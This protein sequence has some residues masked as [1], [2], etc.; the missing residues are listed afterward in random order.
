MRIGWRIFTKLFVVVCCAF[1]LGFGWLTLQ[2][3]TAFATGGSISGTVTDEENNPLANIGVHLYV[4]P[5]G[6]GFW[7]PTGIYG[8]TDLAGQYTIADLDPGPYRLRFIDGG[9]PLGYASEYYNN[10][11]QLADAATVTVADAQNVTIDA[12]LTA[13]SRI[14]GL[15][16]D[17]AGNPIGGI[18]VSL[19]VR[20]E[21]NPNSWV[22]AG[23]QTTTD[24]SG[25]YLVPGIDTGR[26]RVRFADTRS[27]HL[28]STEYYVD[29][30]FAQATELVVLGQAVFVIN[31]QLAAVGTVTGLVTDEA[32]NPLP[33]IT[34]GVY[35]DIESDGWEW[36]NYS[37]T[38]S[39]VTDASGIYTITGV[40]VGPNRICFA[41]YSYRYANECYD[42]KSTIRRATDIMVTTG[43][44]ISVNAALARRGGIS[45]TVVDAVGNPLPFYRVQL[46]IDLED[47]GNWINDATR[48]T[49]TD[50]SG[51]YTFTGLIA[52]VY[53][54]R[55]S[56]PSGQFNAPEFYSDSLTIGGAMDILVQPGQITPNINAQLEPFSH[57]TGRVTD[58][59]DQPLENIWV[60]VYGMASNA[61]SL[62]LPSPLYGIYTQPD[63]TYNLTGLVPGQYYVG[64]ADTFNN[65]LHT[66]YY[67]DAGYLMTADPITVGRVMTVTNINAQLLPFAA[68]NYPP[69]ATSDTAY[70]LKGGTTNTIHMPWG[71]AWTLLNNDRDAEF[72]PITTTLVTSPTYG[73]LTLTANGMFTYTHDGGE[74]TQD[75]FTYRAFDGLHY[76]NV[77]T[78]T[79]I[80]TPVFDL[81]VAVGDAIV[82]DYAG[83]SSVLHSGAASLLANDTNPEGQPLTATLI[84]TPSHGMLSLAPNGTFTYTHDG[85]YTTTD[86]FTYR[87]AT[88][89][90][91]VS[92][93]A[94]VTI[95]IGSPAAI[96]LTKTVWL[97]GLGNDCRGTSNLRIPV[98]TTIAYCY[99]VYNSG[100]ITLTTHS[101]VDDQ[102]GTL[103]ANVPYTLAPGVRYHVIS[104]ATIAVP[105]TN[106][107]TWTATAP[108]LGPITA[109]ATAS[110]TFSTTTDDQDGDGIFDKVE[111]VRDPD[112]D[113]LPNFLDPDADGDWV[114]DRKEWGDNPATARDSNS[115]GLPDYLDP[116][117]PYTQRLYLPVIAK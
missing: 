5:T 70:V 110:V 114:A 12:Q 67:D 4:D 31:A 95:T 91:R 8:M 33:G 10:V 34:V 112:Q 2:P 78:V 13:A 109:T 100:I 87:V 97:A 20:A 50:E 66:E 85:S 106:T 47:N 62:P 43:A 98:S 74:A 48:W 42:N 41:E 81:P 44:K 94:A 88:V 53:R 117:F 92:T 84:A 63:G 77:A 39:R 27:P 79:V 59:Q 111:G 55:F 73:A 108:A 103:L 72:A 11:L 58:G 64:F 21:L 56:D 93:P 83:S 38:Q 76:S 116:L 26:Y 60:S 102:L 9:W 30:T 75:L 65:A 99:T 28:Y 68:V 19:W 115:D 96:E 49:Y 107:V 104:T 14:E 1:V 101:L 24:S 29:A 80:I 54:V 17:A 52:D 51:F 35:N 61:D 7:E 82:V 113:G 22:T 69:F 25:A 15:V 45:G 23:L 89:G 37:Y 105:I 46:Y 16:T 32:G 40:D 90:D 3:A 57:I 86:H 6:N 71:P 36:P 18:Q